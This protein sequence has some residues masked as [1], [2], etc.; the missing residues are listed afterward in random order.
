MK[1]KINKVVTSESQNRLNDEIIL[2]YTILENQR[3]IGDK[4]RIVTKIQELQ[5]Q[6]DPNQN[7]GLYAPDCIL[8]GDGRCICD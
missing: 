1:Q 4:T 7:L 6:V 3:Y 5:K 8:C 2:L